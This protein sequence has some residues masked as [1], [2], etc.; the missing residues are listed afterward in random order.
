[1]VYTCNCNR[2]A[3]CCKELGTAAG[4]AGTAELPAAG[5]SG[6]A[7]VLAAGAALAG[8]RAA[9]LLVV[10][11]YLAWAG[12]AGASVN[13]VGCRA[14]PLTC[15]LLLLLAA[16]SV[17]VA[18]RFGRAAPSC[19]A[20]MQISAPVNLLLQKRR[21]HSP[22][23]HNW[24]ASS[25]ERSPQFRVIRPALVLADMTDMLCSFI[26]LQVGNLLRISVLVAAILAGP[27]SFLVVSAFGKKVPPLIPTDM[28]LPTG[29]RPPRANSTLRL[30]M[31]TSWKPV[32]QIIMTWPKTKNKCSQCYVLFFIMQVC[33][34]KEH[35]CARMQFLLAL[36]RFP[37]HIHPRL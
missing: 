20:K 16:A 21:Q 1:M 7:R 23:F 4:L 11:A 3:G 19:C 22:V 12:K 9:A 10:A 25:L 8:G 6:N 18:G 13:L 26:L 27:R 33:F 5:S 32:M 14:R 15:W 28:R 31:S 17:I 37:G 30:L 29:A 24:S 36:C 35:V 34:Q 2:G